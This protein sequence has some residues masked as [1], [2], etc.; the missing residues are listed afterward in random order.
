MR[1]YLY[2]ILFLL[3]GTS[4]IACPKSPSL[5][6]MDTP[7]TWAIAS[8]SACRMSPGER[9]QTMGWTK[10]DMKIPAFAKGKLQKRIIPAEKD[11]FGDP[12]DQ[13]QIIYFLSLPQFPKE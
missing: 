9:Y 4:S 11:F 13:P 8:P 2:I 12:I 1:N 5:P 7:S 10:G 6:S 3:L